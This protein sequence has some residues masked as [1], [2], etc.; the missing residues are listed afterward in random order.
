MDEL[1]G[2]VLGLQ[3]LRVGLRI[4]SAG[5]TIDQKQI[6][7]FATQF[8]PQPFHLDLDAARQTVFGGLAASGWHTAAL[9]MRL[10]V[11]GGLP[12]A[13]GIIGL[14]GDIAWPHP[15]RPGDLLRVENEITHLA[16][17]QSR[18]GHGVVTVRSETLNDRGEVVQ[19]CTMKILA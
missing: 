4:R 14:G 11:E 9:T 10:N 3:D 18:P 6:L 19:L 2:A 16:P 1:L 7:A 15:V 17:S 5:H 12:I 13:G 8:D